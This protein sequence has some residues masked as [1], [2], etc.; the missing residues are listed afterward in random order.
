MLSRKFVFWVALHLSCGLPLSA[1]AQ[2]RPV[3][4]F[5]NVRIFDGKAAA[6]SAPSNV[7]VRGNKI[8]THLGGAHPGRSPGGHPHHRRAAAAR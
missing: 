6:L 7:L 8:E 4:L 2:D 5:K 1:H 3:T